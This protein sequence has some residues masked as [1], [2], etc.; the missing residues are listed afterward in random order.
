[1]KK[2]KGVV[3]IYNPTTMY[4]NDRGHMEIGGMDSIE[5]AEKY[6]KHLYVYDVSII[7]K[8]FQAFVNSFK[9][10]GVKA[11]V[12]YASKAFSSLAILQIIDQE[13]LSLDVVSTGELYTAIKA[14]V[15]A[16]KIHMHGNN[17]SIEELEMA[18]EH[19][20][21]CIIVDN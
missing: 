18:I 5:L 21:G 19:D 4:V 11:Q 14:G 1:M 6:G 8:N 12:A 15:P 17:K 13:G 9:E 20:I 10:A 7:W 2:T 3:R 16:K